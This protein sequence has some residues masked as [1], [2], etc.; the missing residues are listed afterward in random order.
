MTKTPLPAETHT[1]QNN[2]TSDGVD[3]VTKYKLVHGCL[4]DK[5]Q[6]PLSDKTIFTAG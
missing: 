2:D 3:A 4:R 6:K 1:E 5:P